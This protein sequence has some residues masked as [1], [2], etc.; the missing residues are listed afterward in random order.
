MARRV[1]DLDGAKALT[2]QEGLSDDSLSRVQ[3]RLALP[4]THHVEVSC[5]KEDLFLTGS[6]ERTGMRIWVN[7][8]VGG[9][10]PLTAPFTQMP[11]SGIKPFSRM[12]VTLP[13]S[14]KPPVIPTTT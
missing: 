3:L 11:Q 9:G 4:C 8:A 10:T 13:A 12:P 14:G 1:T 6:G 2:E 5:Q 7:G